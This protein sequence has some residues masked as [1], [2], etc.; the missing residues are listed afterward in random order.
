[1]QI[2][3]L[4]LGRMGTAVAGRLLGTGYDVTVWNRTPG[5][6][7]ALVKRGAQ[8][9]PDIAQAI[10]GADVTLTLLTADAA[11]QDV[12]FGRQGIIAHAAAHTI[13]VDM[14]TVSPST[15]REVA[16]AAGHARFVDA[17]ILGSPSAVEVGGA[18]LLLGGEEET[19]KRLNALWSNLSSGYIYC[20]SSGAAAT[21]KLLS[22]LI[23]VGSTILLS[24][25]VMTARGNGIDDTVVRQVFGQSPAVASGVQT[26]LDDIITGEYEGWWTVQLAQKD[27]SL[28]L[29]LAEITGTNVQLGRAAEQVLRDSEREGHGQLDLSV[30]AEIARPR[31]RPDT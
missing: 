16:A 25:A 26:R 20:G 15:S 21:M 31:I 18:K 13:L 3:V 12:Y 1:M 30:V 29:T 6:A 2:A 10:K 24:E 22:N 8:A 28:A 27:I 14:S 19:I 17:P 4:G 11:V 23:L 7:G 9:A 5:K